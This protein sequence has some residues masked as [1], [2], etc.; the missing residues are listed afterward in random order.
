MRISKLEE[1]PSKID[2]NLGRHLGIDFS[3]IFFDFGG[4]NGAK[5]G[6]EIDKKSIKKG[7]E[8]RARA[9]PRNKGPRIRAGRAQGRQGRPREFSNPPPGGRAG[10]RP[11]PSPTSLA[12]LNLNASPRGA[13]TKYRT[14]FQ[15]LDKYLLNAHTP[16]GGG[17]FDT[18]TFT[19]W[20]PSWKPRLKLG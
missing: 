16:L 19:S 9:M 13:S 14:K 7:H 2:L 8:K 12:R 1:N 18:A 3:S 17:F 10:T 20:K 4:Q 11:T 6:G 5:L 15:G